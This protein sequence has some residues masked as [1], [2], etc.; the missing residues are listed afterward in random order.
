MKHITFCL[1]CLAPQAHAQ[2]LTIEQFRTVVAGSTLSYANPGE[3]PFGIEYYGEDG[4]IVWAPSDGESCNTGT[5]V[6]GPGD[7][8]CLDY[9][10]F[11]FCL[12]FFAAANGLRGIDTEGN[13]FYMQFTDATSACFPDE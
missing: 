1:I 9:G 12:T 8:I 10:G 6:E 7:Q 13:K 3:A 2:S 4:T 11:D 5:I